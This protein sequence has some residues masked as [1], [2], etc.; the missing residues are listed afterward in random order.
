M[1][2]RNLH[3]APQNIDASMKAFSLPITLMK[4]DALFEKVLITTKIFQF[5]TID[6][7]CIL[8]IGARKYLPNQCIPLISR[9]RIVRVQ[10]RRSHLLVFEYL[11]FVVPIYK[12]DNYFY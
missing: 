11:I 5:K 6:D 4:F 2:S 10:G 7:Y 8:S 1:N 12:K 9:I 3:Y